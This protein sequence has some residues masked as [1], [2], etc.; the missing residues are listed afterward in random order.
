MDSLEKATFAAGCFWGVEEYF[1]NLPGVTGTAVGYI[2]GDK[3]NPTYKDVCYT[4]TGHAE[5]VEIT[6]DPTQISFETLLGAFFELHDPTQ[7][8][9]QG[10]DI[11]DQYRSAVFYHSDAQRAAS[12]ALIQR[13]TEAK[14]FPR[15]IVTQVVPA[16]E[17]WRAEEYHQQYLAKR[18]LASCHI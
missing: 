4:E 5:A 18:G 17:F 15:P 12:E 2:G 10:P 14:A 9:R 8:N 13:L 7:L 11:G 16:T 1:R 3:P 6:Y